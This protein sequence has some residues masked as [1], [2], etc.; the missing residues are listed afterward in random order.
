MAFGLSLCGTPVPSSP[1]DRT[2]PQEL[3][4]AIFCRLRGFPK[5]LIDR[6][7]VEPLQCSVTIGPP[8]LSCPPPLSPRAGD[9]LVLGGKEVN[10]FHVGGSWV[11]VEDDA[12]DRCRIQG[13]RSFRITPSTVRR[14]FNFLHL[15]NIAPTSDWPGLDSEVTPTCVSLLLSHL[16]SL[17]SGLGKFLVNKT[18]SFFISLFSP[19]RLWTP[20]SALK[21]PLY[22]FI[23]RRFCLLKIDILP[24]LPKIPSGFTTSNNIT[25]FRSMMPSTR[26]PAVQISSPPQFYKSVGWKN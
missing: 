17:V 18:P 14:Q 19:S 21:E 20:T 2:N 8:P 23:R 25:F 7:W 12:R 4:N 5:P 26:N 3:W 6:F 13:F 11:F 16:P 10:V 15:R 1:L 9:W 22:F 24:L